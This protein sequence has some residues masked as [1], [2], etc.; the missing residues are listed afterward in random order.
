MISVAQDLRRTIGLGIPQL[1]VEPHSFDSGAPPG[2]GRNFKP[3]LQN[4]TR[5]MG[6][7][8]GI[9][10]ASL[11]RTVSRA[12]SKTV[13]KV[14]SEGSLGRDAAERFPHALLLPG[15]PLLSEILL[16]QAGNATQK[17]QPRRNAHQKGKICQRSACYRKPSHRKICRRRSC[18]G[19]VGNA[20]AS[21]GGTCPSGDTCFREVQAGKDKRGH[22]TEPDDLSHREKGQSQRFC[23]LESVHDIKAIYGKAIY[24]KAVY[25][26]V[27]CRSKVVCRRDSFLLRR[28]A[29]IAASF[30]GS[31][32]PQWLVFDRQ[33]GLSTAFSRLITC[34]WKRRPH[35]LVWSFERQPGG[36]LQNS[37]LAQPPIPTQ[38]AV[39]A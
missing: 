19:H 10:R 1:R 38:P 7:G 5:K 30:H 8:G 13:S 11:A 9:R 28:P 15:P 18:R 27:F 33:T 32:F 39:P 16:P 21:A 22:E 36:C 31:W 29:S 20:G 23:D 17:K 12:V 35:L 37:Q 2:T 3:K 34:S 4:G 6:H 26:K 14:V 25:C 24:D